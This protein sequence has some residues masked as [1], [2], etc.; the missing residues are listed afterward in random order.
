MQI[1]MKFLYVFFVLFCVLLSGCTYLNKT[2]YSHYT[3]NDDY[4]A[5][6]ATWAATIDICADKEYLE[7]N[8]KNITR[9]VVSEY[10]SYTV[11]NNDVLE[12]AYISQKVKLDIMSDSSLNRQCQDVHQKLQ[13]DVEFLAKKTVEVK[14]LR[15]QQINRLANYSYSDNS[16]SSAISSNSYANLKKSLDASSSSPRGYGT[17]RSTVT[18]VYESSECIGAVVNGRCAG[19]INPNPSNVLRKKCYGTMINGECQGAYGY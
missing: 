16:Y 18:P 1:R 15:Q 10:L 5:K 11:F 14:M 17:G 12:N 7:P 13:K 6:F 8:D 3:M 9:S 19:T 4:A 2:M